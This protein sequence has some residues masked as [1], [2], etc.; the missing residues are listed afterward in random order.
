MR[1]YVVIDIVSWLDVQLLQARAKASDDVVASSSFLLE[2]NGQLCL[3]SYIL[4]FKIPVFATATRLFLNLPTPARDPLTSDPSST[5]TLGAMN[6]P[7]TNHGCAEP[8][9]RSRVE[10]PGAHKAGRV[11]PRKAHRAESSPQI[12]RLR[13]VR[14]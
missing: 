1:R 2:G 14:G 3:K 4:L 11:R 5:L 10:A 7:L 13:D 6:G 12:L 9:L 8:Q